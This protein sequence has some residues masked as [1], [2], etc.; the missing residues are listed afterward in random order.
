MKKH[1]WNIFE[2]AREERTDGD[3]FQG[4][5]STAARCWL[6][7]LTAEG[8]QYQCMEGMDKAAVLA[9]LDTPEKQAVLVNGFAQATEDHYDELVRAFN[10]GDR[11]GFEAILADMEKAAP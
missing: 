7:G 2:V 10:A 6:N 3:N 1:Y 9:E 5:L 4:D 11:E 8:K